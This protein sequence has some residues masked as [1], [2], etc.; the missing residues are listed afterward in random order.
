MSKDS[1]EY[2]SV[3]REKFRLDK[4][5]FQFELGGGQDS[6]SRGRAPGGG[7]GLGDFEK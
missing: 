3:E 5:K 6:G 2:M 7:V 1:V 4:Y